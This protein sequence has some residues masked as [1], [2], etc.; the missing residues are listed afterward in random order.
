[1]TQQ[2]AGKRTFQ[3]WNATLK[4]TVVE[5]NYHGDNQARSPFSSV[6]AGLIEFASVQ[7]LHRL[8]KA[9]L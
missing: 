6:S 5:L 8:E 1:M 2:A 9:R 4:K 3:I 7:S